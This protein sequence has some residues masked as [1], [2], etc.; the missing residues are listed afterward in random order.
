[1]DREIRQRREEPQHD[2]IYIVQTEYGYMFNIKQR[3]S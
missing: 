1:M 2:K 3:P